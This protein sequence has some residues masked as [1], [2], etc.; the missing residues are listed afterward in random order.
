MKDMF[1]KKYLEYWSHN[2]ATFFSAF[3]HDV[4][5]R[6]DF[7]GDAKCLD[8]KNMYTKGKLERFSYDKMWRFYGKIYFFRYKY[9][10]KCRIFFW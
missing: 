3:G 1:K 2:I 6:K 4:Q 10:H 5:K 8:Y 9:L 7:E